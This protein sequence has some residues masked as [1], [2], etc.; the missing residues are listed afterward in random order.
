M[1]KAVCPCCGSVVPADRL[2]DLVELVE[3]IDRLDIWPSTAVMFLALWRANGR[4]VTHDMFSD[5]SVHFRRP[6]L[7][8]QS[9]TSA[10]KHLQMAIRDRKLPLKIETITGFGYRMKR[11]DPTWNWRDLPLT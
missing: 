11:L 2:P 5:Y 1:S 3:V 4:S 10:K 9:I 6:V 8:E 7:S